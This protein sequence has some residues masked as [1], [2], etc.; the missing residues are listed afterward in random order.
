MTKLLSTAPFLAIAVLA[1]ISALAQ[2]DYD[3]EARLVSLGIELGDPAPPLGNYVHAVTT[4]T[5]VFLAGH[6]PAQ[7]D[8]TYV[9]GKLGSDLTIEQGYEAARLTAVAL[10]TS[11][12][13]EIGNLGRV[14]RI[15]RVFGMVNAVDGFGRQPE[16]ING[17]SD[18]LIEVFG[19]RGRHARAAVGVASLPFMI[20]MVAEI[21]S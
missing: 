10:L 2:D 6:G 12:E 21:D 13:K 15:V 7:S 18:L 11:L 16:V 1:A 14:S 9:A 4:G 20:E 17:A 8:G 19:A 5:L 3:P